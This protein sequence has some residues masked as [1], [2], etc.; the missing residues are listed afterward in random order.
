LISHTGR[1]HAFLIFAMGASAAVSAL[2]APSIT[3]TRVTVEPAEL[4]RGESFLLR[5]E[6]EGS[7]V[8]VKSFRVRTPYAVGE[9]ELPPGFVRESGKAVFAGD[10]GA[11]FD[12]GRHDQDPADGAIAV[13]ISTRNWSEGTHY[14]VLFAHNRPG[15][16]SH[17][18]DHRNIRLDIGDEAVGVRVLAKHEG[19]A[20]GPLEFILPDTVAQPGEPLV[21]G[22]GI[23]DG[24]EGE[25]SLRLRPPYTWCQPEVLSGFTYYD[26]E[27]VGYVEDGPD[28]TILD[29]GTLD[30]D[31]AEGSVRL[32]LSTEGWP[33]G[34]HFLSLEAPGF[35]TV[36]APYDKPGES[37]RDFAVH[38][39]GPDDQ[40]IVDVGPSK[41]FAPGTHFS[42]IVSLGEGRVLTDTHYSEDYGE[43][44]R[45][46]GT[47]IPRPN[48]LSDGTVIAMSYR[49]LPVEGQKGIYT[50]KLW[51]SEDGGSTVQGPLESK[52]TVPKARA[53]LGHGPHVGPLFGRSIVELE[54]GDL[55]SAM[56]GWF[57]GDT[58]PDRYRSG[59]TMRRSY[60]GISHD[61][62]RSWEYLSSVA[63]RP[64]LGNEG[65]SELVIRKLPN[66]DILA[67]V[68]TGGN[69]NA[70]WQDNP[71]MISR[72]TD[73]GKTWSPVRRTGFE[74]VWP[75]LCVMQDGTLVCSTGRP[76]AFIMFSTDD[77]RTWTDAT[78]IDAERYSGYTGI[79]EVRPGELLM[80]Y[81]ARNWRDPETGERSHQ[82]RLVRIKVRKR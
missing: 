78:P 74:G 41:P 23:R 50:G 72:S 44:W 66:G 43:T 56:Y 52:V 75:D 22:A 28:H 80:G 2:A 9:A 46:L 7:G 32:E 13:K 65:Y 26:D 20:E 15:T 16:G 77:G 29:N 3:L 30:R 76:G 81:G 68:R 48:V 47:A 42:A 35:S 69:S 73:G 62:G 33:P 61:R 11:I 4:P 79:C 40:F 24:V 63:Y 71:L 39:P 54:T 31:P 57:D 60:V 37:Y 34:A 49:A 25:L 6:A 10:Q 36:R 53:A 55:I 18:L 1:M 21:C 45:R 59:G 12:N 70:G 51:L 82:L 58:Q 27:K 14:L 64:F 67:L 5:A 38:V 19:V 8:E 17:I